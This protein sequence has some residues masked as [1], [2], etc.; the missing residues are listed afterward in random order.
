MMA[1][2]AFFSGKSLEEI[3]LD[4]DNFNISEIFK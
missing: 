1:L 2:T 3:K 4:D